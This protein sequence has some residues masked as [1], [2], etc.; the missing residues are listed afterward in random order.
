MNVAFHGRHEYPAFGLHG[1]GFFGFYKWYKVSHGLFH[2]SC[3]LNHLRQEH[4]PR[5]K[6]IAN[7]I[8]AIHQRAFN[9]VNRPGRRQTGFFC[10]INDILVDTFN[11]R[12]GKPLAGGLF[13]PG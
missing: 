12:V 9:H 10:V 5:T 13:S 1:A 7:L 11:Q 8:H 6:K 4:F 3:T 2:H